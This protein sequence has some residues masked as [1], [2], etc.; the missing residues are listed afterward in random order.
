MSGNSHGS[1]GSPPPH[2]RIKRDISPKSVTGDM[3]P[4][5]PSR[6]GLGPSFSDTPQ[7]RQIAYSGALRAPP[8]R[9]RL[10][11]VPTRGRGG[12]G[13]ARGQFSSVDR[14][15]RRQQHGR[16]QPGYSG[17]SGYSD[18][19][20]L[21][22][23][24]TPG[25]SWAAERHRQRLDRLRLERDAGTPS[26]AGDRAALMETQSLFSEPQF[27]RG[28]FSDQQSYAGWSW[29]YPDDRGWGGQSERGGYMSDTQSVCGYTSDT[30]YRPSDRN[31]PPP[32]VHATN[33]AIRRDVE[34]WSRPGNYT[35]DT[36]RDR[37]DYY[38][39]DN[40]DS[41]D[42][43]PY[44]D[45]DMESN[46]SALNKKNPYA[47]GSTVQF[48]GKTDATTTGAATATT[49]TAA[50]TASTT[51]PKSILRQTTT[52][53]N[54][55]SDRNDGSLSDT[56]LGGPGISSIHNKNQPGMGQKS[57]STSQLSDTGRQ[58]RLGL[59]GAKRT[60]ITVHRSEEVIPC[61]ISVDKR[62]IRQGTSVSSD[63]ETDIFPD[64]VSESWLTTIS[65]ENQLSEFIEGKMSIN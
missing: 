6:P 22:E 38:S 28:Q 27:S 26:T 37:T 44:H 24:Q 59:I 47:I 18:T 14:G 36:E 42:T 9:R 55:D 50:T 17:N 11:Q 53:S 60:R 29:K 51:H 21:S 57:N 23:R 4:G 61:N 43:R 39:R 64:T 33:T 63:G 1:S 2:D 16:P 13:P 10:P 46:F 35:R 5:K 19:E 31:Y 58:R 15:H 54:A 65:R 62:L 8:S 45:T 25:D 20:M 41:R 12:P 40:R 56:A 3:G 34:G 32:P 7:N 48:S 49:T 52:T 30:G